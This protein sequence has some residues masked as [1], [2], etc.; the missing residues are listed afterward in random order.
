MRG[1]AQVP[2]IGFSRVLE[3]VRGMPECDV[4]TWADV[5]RLDVRPDKGVI[6][7]RCN[8]RWEVQL[9]AASGDVLQSAYR[10][11]DLIESIHDG[12]WFHDKAKLWLF[13]PVAL[14]LL[15]LWGSGLYLFLLPYL[16]KRRRARDSAA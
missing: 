13:V 15:G 3:V 11:S 4:S 12:S 16:V 5:D 6:K 10:R 8:N 7:V 2:T 9:D 1:E 14:I